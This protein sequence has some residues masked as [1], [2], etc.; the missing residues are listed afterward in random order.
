MLSFSL[1]SS[2]QLQM[3]LWFL[4]NR[5]SLD[6]LSS[7]LGEGRCLTCRLRKDPG[8]ASVTWGEC[9]MS[10][11]A[12]AHSPNGSRMCLRAIIQSE[13]V[14]G[15]GA[16]DFRSRGGGWG[17]VSHT[18]PAEE[19]LGF[20][21]VLCAWR[22]RFSVFGRRSFIGVDDLLSAHPRASGGERGGLCLTAVAPPHLHRDSCLCAP[23]FHRCILARPISS[24]I[25]RPPP[26]SP[27]ARGNAAL[28]Q[29]MHM[30]NHYE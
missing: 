17:W 16:S 12:A 18:P 29:L 3:Q 26:S 10:R 9:V 4:W 25:P 14:C 28:C 19:H 5:N 21:G 2:L 6:S 30:Y 24:A 22:Q 23:A 1:L 13:A 11:N 20:F 7:V 15:M 27:A 8:G